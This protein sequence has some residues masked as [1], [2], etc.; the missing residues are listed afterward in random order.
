MTPNAIVPSKT[1]IAMKTVYSF[2]NL[3]QQNIALSGIC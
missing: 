3:K 1:T 2:A